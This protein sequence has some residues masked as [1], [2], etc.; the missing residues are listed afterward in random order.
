MW[1]RD[2]CLSLGSRVARLRGAAAP[3]PPIP[4]TD[5]PPW[6][7]AI[8]PL[9]VLILGANGF[10]GSNLTERILGDPDC[11]WNVGTELYL[12]ACQG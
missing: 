2:P 9:N 8:M 1:T 5:N 4:S 10:I 3:D 6:G 11:D 12:V 7:S